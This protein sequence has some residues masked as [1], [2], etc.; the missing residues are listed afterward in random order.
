M[1]KQPLLRMEHI[2]KSFPGVQALNDVDFEV[3]PG[4]ILGFLGENGAGKSTLIKILSGIH[5]K[6]QGTIWFNGQAINP[7]T[8]HEAQNLGI[9]TIHQELALIPY[10]SVAEN[11]FLNNE[12]R[13]G[14]GMGGLP[15]DESAGRKNFCTTWGGDIQGKQLIRGS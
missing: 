10:L 12:P 2:S 1:E 5:G 13:R 7:H 14:F 4:E 3:Y 8:P 11:I 9:S 15:A 6:D